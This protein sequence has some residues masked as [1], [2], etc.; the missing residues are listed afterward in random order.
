MAK[1]SGDTQISLLGYGG[2]LSAISESNAASRSANNSLS[3][4][5]ARAVATYLEER[6]S[7]LGLNGFSISIAATSAG[8]SDSGQGASSIVVATLS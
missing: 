4:E 6:L 8:G 1:G 7:A 2:R 3:R 5:R